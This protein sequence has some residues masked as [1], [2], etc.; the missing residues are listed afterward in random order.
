MKL[1]NNL[2]SYPILGDGRRDYLDASF[3][4]DC[5]VENQFE[6]LVIK[7]EFNLNNVPELNKLIDE[8]LAAYCMHI[9]CSKSSYRECITQVNTKFTKNIPSDLLYENVEIS[10]FIISTNEIKNY[11]SNAFNPIYGDMNFDI[12]N[13]QILAFG[14]NYI[15]DVPKDNEDLASSDSII[16]YVRLEDKNDGIIVNM[17][18]DNILVCANDKLYKDICQLGELE[19]KSTVLSM[20]IMPTM[21]TVLNHI[22]DESYKNYKW[23]KVI[24]ALLKQNNIDIDKDEDIMLIVQKIFKNPISSALKELKDKKYEELS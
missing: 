17:L 9:E 20:I 6:E 18:D 10:T 1:D 21:I 7:C 22:S 24:T 11:H 14:K 19:Y 12:N 3:E 2:S 15:I 16:K 13:H 5:K 8:G 4:V 23:H